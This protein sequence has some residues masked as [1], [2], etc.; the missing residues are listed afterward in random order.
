MT[1]RSELPNSEQLT[2]L[3]NSILGE[4]DRP[5]Q[6]E[7]NDGHSQDQEW[8]ENHSQS[9]RNGDIDEALASANIERLWHRSRTLNIRK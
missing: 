1:K 6:R 4:E 9:H 3:A 5:P 2:V 7:C 8:K